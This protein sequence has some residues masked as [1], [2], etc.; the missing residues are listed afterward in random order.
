MPMKNIRRLRSHLHFFCGSI[1]H[2]SE[3]RNGPPALAQRKMN[4]MKAMKYSPFAITVAMGLECFS[5]NMAVAQSTYEPYTVITLAGKSILDSNHNPIGGNVDGT[6]YLARFN[7]LQGIAIDSGGNL[8]VCDMFNATIRKVAPAGTNW[9]V[10]TLAGKAGQTGITDGMGD[11]AR[12]DWPGGIALDR[13]GALYIGD[14]NNH[15]IRKM[16]LVDTNWSVTTFAGRPGEHGTIDGPWNEAQFYWPCGTAVDGS[17][18]IYVADY[19]NNT[20]RKITPAGI[21]TTVAGEAGLAGTMDGVGRSARFNGPIAVAVNQAGDVFVSDS[22][23]HTIRKI[24]SSGVVATVA[25]DGGVAG[26]ADGINNNSRL[27]TPLGVAVDGAGNLYVQ[28]C[29]NNTIRKVSPVG[30]DWVVTTLAGEPAVSGS[31][32]G[33]GSKAKFYFFDEALG[34]S[35][36]GGGVAVDKSGNLFVEDYNNNTIRMVYRPLTIS[37]TTASPSFAG[38]SFN[39][40]LAGPAGQ[41]VVV[42]A[43]SNLVDWSPVWTNTFMVGEL[44]F[45]NT[46]NGVQAQGFYRARKQ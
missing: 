44:K 45:S 32:D 37:L 4:F 10:T 3:S 41:S 21:V 38:G 16:T 20:I 34:I 23:N 43:S 35:G 40:G 9:V 39:F 25:G 18:N 46:N 24:S 14:I 30:M 1:T 12:F 28:D 19:G 26:T 27:N 11:K 17:G 15:T 8:F 6:N 7:G 33:K 31:A 5:P 36:W 22:G 13:A 42:D 2:C 29:G